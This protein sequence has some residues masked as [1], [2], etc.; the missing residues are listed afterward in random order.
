MFNWLRELK[1]IWREPRVCLSCEVLKVEL[2]NE[3]REKEMLLTHVLTPR[4]QLPEREVAPEPQVPITAKHVPW[5]VKQQMLE[6]EDRARAAQIMSEFKKKDVEVRQGHTAPITP[7]TTIE[8]LENVLG[9]V[10]E[11]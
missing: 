7:A 6:A 8:D 5:R 4:P 2:S 10:E 1:E 9:I 11:K 3:R